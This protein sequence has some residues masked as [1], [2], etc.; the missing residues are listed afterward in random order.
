MIFVI[1]FFPNLFLSRSERSVDQLGNHVR[2]VSG[3]LV[4]YADDNLAKM[5]PDGVIPSP[6]MQGAPEF[7]AKEDPNVVAAA[8]PRRPDGPRM[9][10][11]SPA[12]EKAGAR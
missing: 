10:E 12:V 2:V 1:G 11:P 4:R 8:E 9:L 5:L 3:A 7:E 6:F